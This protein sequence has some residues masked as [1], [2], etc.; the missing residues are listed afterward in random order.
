MTEKRVY[1]L[2]RAYTS[3]TAS[4]EEEMELC[5]WM[6][7]GVDSGVLRK[8]V[9]QLVEEQAG[10]KFTGVDWEE[11]YRR[12]LERT[13]DDTRRSAIHRRWTIMAAAAALVLLIG[14][15]IFLATN[16]KQDWGG[17][18]AEKVSAYQNDIKPG[19]TR[20]I[21]QAGNVR[22][23]LNATDTSFMLAGNAIR[24]H[25]GNIRIG[26][27][28]PVLYT[29]TTPPGGVYS[30]VLDDGTKIQL[31]A[32]SRLEYPSVFDD[33]IRQVTLTGEAYFDVYTDPSRPFIV[34]TDR[35]E[36]R[37]LGTA[38]DVDAYPDGGEVTT[39]LVEGKV[40][41]NSPHSRLVLRP[42][43]QTQ[44]NSEGTL[45]LH[46]EADID[47]AIAWKNG[48]FW[49]DKADIHKIMR[50]LERWYDVRVRYSPDLKPHY[51]GAV[52]GRGNN[53]SQ[54]LHMLEATGSVHFKVEGR[55]VTVLP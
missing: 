10:E 51:F 47:E 18:T 1:D 39:T 50:Q 20:A 31:N 29:L 25:G 12:V 42:G 26:D 43:Q 34:R 36:V 3:G 22:I 5:Q 40:M 8:Y 55:M 52:I 37:V 7:S 4:D 53:I 32:D 23:A 27:V 30:M 46:K 19:G 24:I 15:W 48:Y 21:L 49:F 11:I 17:A 14:S 35:Q 54:I 38:F 45:I 9:R 44:L 6:A 41:I 28:K 13:R 2:L 33:S 16:R